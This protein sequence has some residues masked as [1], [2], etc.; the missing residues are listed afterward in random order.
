MRKS[1]ICYCFCQIL[2]K[3][4]SHRR[5]I[6]VFAADQKDV[7]GEGGAF[8]GEADGPRIMEQGKDSFGQEPDTESGI[9][10]EGCGTGVIIFTD[11]R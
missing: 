3:A 9:T 11:W 4:L 8:Q 2:Y 5:Q 10:P 6:S 1:R 7:C